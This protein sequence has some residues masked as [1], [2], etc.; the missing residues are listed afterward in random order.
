MN[1]EAAWLKSN[2]EILLSQIANSGTKELSNWRRLVIDL[3][4]FTQTISQPA[5]AL[6]SLLFLLVGASVFGHLA[7][8]RTKPNESL[9]IAR[10]ISEKAKLSTIF[11][12]QQREKLEVQFAA[13]HAEAITEILAGTVID[14]SNQDQVAMLNKKFNQEVDTMRAKIAAAKPV[15]APAATVATPTPSMEEEDVVVAGNGKEDKG[16]QLEIKNDGNDTAVTATNTTEV[17]V[18]ASPVSK[19]PAEILEEAK[20]LFDNKEYDS[21]L[22]KLKEVK[23]LIK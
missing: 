9:Y 14:E 6:G 8:N 4:S 22:D 3:R 2:R 16:L 7:F 20:T 18:E 21:A 17:M 10:I 15:S 23:E 11:D 5:M 12:S 13:N 1:P 19:A